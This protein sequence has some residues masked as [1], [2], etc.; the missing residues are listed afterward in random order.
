VGKMLGKKGTPGAPQKLTPELI[1]KLCNF[2]R[3]GSYPETAAASCGIH[4][5]TFHKWLRM[6]HARK[7]GLHTE[8]SRAVE[9][10]MADAEN[11]DLA[12]IDMG[13]TGVEAEY[14]RDEH[15][16]L[17]YVEGKPVCIRFA[18]KRD[19]K[20]AAWKLERRNPRRYQPRQVLEHV[21]PEGGPV[22]VAQLTD[23]QLEA[24]LKR[25][26]ELEKASGP[27]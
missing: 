20:A 10:A 27:K 14:L 24:E 15:G 16:K 1:E 18:Q 7:Q 26:E 5:D 2:I 9:K 19:W 21:G 4:K 3:G 12:A 22:Q 8:L 17:V 13:A 6:G 23:E 11:R 25:L